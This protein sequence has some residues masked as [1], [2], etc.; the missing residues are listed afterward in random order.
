LIAANHGN[1]YKPV[2]PFD[3]DFSIDVSFVALY[4][5][6]PGDLEKGDIG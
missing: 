1:S 6:L 2:M 5:R 4:P 3:E